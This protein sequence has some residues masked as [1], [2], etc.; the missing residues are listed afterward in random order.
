MWEKTNIIDSDFS[1]KRKKKQNQ[2]S[3]KGNKKVKKWP[4]LEKTIT[5]STTNDAD[6]LQIDTNC[7]WFEWFKL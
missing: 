7:V 5:D 1:I 6:A 4:A 3:K 2:I